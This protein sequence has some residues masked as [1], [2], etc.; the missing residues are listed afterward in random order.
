MASSKRITLREIARHADTSTMAVS[1]VLNGARSNTRV[2]D[3]TRRRITEIAASLNYSP[4]ALA[5]GLKR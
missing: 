1:V 4:N 5:Q 3:A 2:S